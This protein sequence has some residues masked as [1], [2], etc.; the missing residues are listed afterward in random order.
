MTQINSTR[1]SRRRVELC[2]SVTYRAL[3]FEYGPTRP[4]RYAFIWR[5]TDRCY[6]CLNVQACASVAFCCLQVEVNCDPCRPFTERE[7]NTGRRWLRR[8]LHAASVV[9]LICHSNKLLMSCSWRHLYTNQSADD[10]ND[11]LIWQE[12]PLTRYVVLIRLDGWTHGPCELVAW[13]SMPTC[14]SRQQIIHSA[15]DSHGIW[16]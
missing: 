14:M 8:A 11:A 6:K 9:T 5:V 1:P 16:L 10:S 15:I 3:K 2:R 4:I 7:E 12:S 13:N